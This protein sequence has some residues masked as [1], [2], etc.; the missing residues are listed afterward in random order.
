MSSGACPDRRRRIDSLPAS[1][2]KPDCVKVVTISWVGRHFS[3]RARSRAFR[4]EY[5]SVR[6]SSEPHTCKITCLQIWISVGQEL[7]RASLVPNPCASPGRQRTISFRCLSC[8]ILPSTWKKY[9]KAN[10]FLA[11]DCPLPE[12][13]SSHSP[14]SLFRHVL[15][16]QPDWLLSDRLSRTDGVYRKAIR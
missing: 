14:L 13:I 12:P 15:E 11:T 16:G 7:W 3:T 5:Q 10:L 9:I 4:T 8:N 1:P 2:A 6:S